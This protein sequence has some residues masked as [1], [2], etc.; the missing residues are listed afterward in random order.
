MD[1]RTLEC[2]CMN[3]GVAVYLVHMSKR[4]LTD[5]VGDFK[6]GDKSDDPPIICDFC[7]KAVQNT[8]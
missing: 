6:R 4:R 3:K 2:E 7:G 5:L 1:V 8:R